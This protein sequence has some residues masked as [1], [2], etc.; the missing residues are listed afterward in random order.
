MKVVYVS[1]H[2][3]LGGAER[4]TMDLVALHDRAVVE[5][6]VVFLS[7]GPLVDEVR[8][9]GIP[10]EVL[11]AP[12]L[13]SVLAARG[14]RRALAARLKEL[15]ADLVHGVMAW[16][17][18]YAGPAARR[19]G[20]PAIWFQH[21]IPSWSHG[22]DLL[23][24]FSPA[25]RILANSELTARAQRAINPRRV[26]IEVVRPGTRLPESPREE[27]RARGRA[28]LGLEDEHFVAAQVARLVPGKGHPTFL[29]AAQSLCNA[30]ADVRIVIAGAALFD[31]EAGY[32]AALRRQ[33]ADL[34]IADR[35]LFVGA[36]LDAALVLGAADVAVHVPDGLESYGLAVVEAMAAGAA[37]VA[38]DAGAVREIVVPGVTAVLVPPGDP[39][40]LATALL[41]VHDDA[42]GRARMVQAALAAVRERFDARLVTQR[43]EAIYQAVRGPR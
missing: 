8:A 41:S 30:R 3:H 22:L 17:H 43:V 42:E 29:A 16:G 14:F 13:R 5:P 6:A 18:A 26:P 36:E 23:A 37:V 33:A 1:P 32:S 25:A 31:G 39:E 19:A 24:A 4:V 2:A 10:A 12:R 9:L 11:P 7:P 27:R 21:N 28:A 15:C 38:A 34:G 40:M 35:V 20:I